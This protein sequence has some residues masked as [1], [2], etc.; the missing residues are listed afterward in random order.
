MA[1]KMIDMT[2]GSGGR[3]MTRLI[4]DLFLPAFDN[5]WLSAMNDHAV[6]EP[7]SGRLVM[8]TDSNVVRPLFFPGGD[9]GSLAVHG[10]VND[11][12]MAG[13]TLL[14]LSA[15][16]ILE[17][18]FPMETLSRIVSSMAASAK[19][20]GI[21]IVTGDTKVV[22]RGK[23]DGIFINTTGIG[24]VPE[25]MS[26]SPQRVVP[27]D[28]ILVSGFI[29]DHG[30][31]IM[32]VRENLSIAGQFL[33]DSAPLHDL[34]ASL[35]KSGAEIHCLRDPTRG[36]VATLLNEIA[37]QSGTGALIEEEAV[38]VRDEVRALCEVLGIDPLYVANEGKLVAYCAARDAER[39]L[40]A[41]RAHPLGRAGAIVGEVTQN[42][43][44]FVQVRTSF[45]GYRIVDW[46]SGDPLPRIC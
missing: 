1:T 20:V 32:A 38:P 46:L 39:L 7:S 28:K 33:S 42:K 29:G 31:A 15:G 36:G 18:G 43:G 19:S 45:G 9:I 41:M 34:V 37:A 23:G 4:E 2:H 44:G 24:F 13:A 30:S 8:A 11:V 22:E 3:S 5:P 21:P 12:A 10:T 27:G 26:L 6:L 17:E 16:F 25:T 14:C 35:I 40:E